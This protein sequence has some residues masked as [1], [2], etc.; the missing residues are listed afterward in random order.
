MAEETAGIGNAAALVT[1]ARPQG[2][3]ILQGLKMAESSALAK[4]KME[5]AAEAKRQAQQDRIMQHLTFAEKFD[6]PT[7]QD[8]AN[9]EAI[10]AISAVSEAVKSGD[11]NR[12]YLIRDQTIRN[13]KSLEPLNNSLKE[14]SKSKSPSL[15]RFYNSYVEGY[16]KGGHEAGL[17][18]MMAKNPSW[19]DPNDSVVQPSVGGNFN[20][21]PVEDINYDKYFDSQIKEIYPNDI[22]SDLSGKILTIKRDITQDQINQSAENL[23]NDDAFRRST[24]YKDEFNDFFTKNYAKGNPDR[25]KD[26]GVQREAFQDFIAGKLSN[27]K[28]Q[29]VNPRYIDPKN[30]VANYDGGATTGKYT[31]NTDRVKAE[32][33]GSQGDIFYGD[34][35]DKSDEYFRI[36][37]RNT[38]GMEFKRVILPQNMSWNF[39]IA[40]DPNR[41][42]SFSAG[43]SR[44][45][46]PKELYQ[47]PS[48]GKIYLLYGDG[49]EKNYRQYW[50]EA[51]STDLKN[52][53]NFYKPNNPIDIANAIYNNGQGVDLRPY[54][55]KSGVSQVKTTNTSTPKTDKSAPKGK[56][57]S[58]TL[59]FFTKTTKK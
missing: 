45:T 11:N 8:M 13:Q 3:G 49:N 2:L 7:V 21:F 31:F 28:Q 30:N 24:L 33:L 29:K 6:E 25:L 27:Y 32:T 37:G 57:S 50:M 14:L 46:L 1:R 22:T 47:N 41:T 4:A 40:K 51:S 15:N 52:I 43:A 26:K 20:V 9:K 19:I 39:N 44:G 54:A 34:T 58:S 42:V 23:Y 38:K 35:K 10:G 18:G 59:G 12:A 56:A 5:A 55:P 36:L 16:K 48:T 53:L 17:Q